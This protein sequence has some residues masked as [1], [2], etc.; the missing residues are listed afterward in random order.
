YV[1]IRRGIPD[2][3]V[4]REKVF[5]G[6]HSLGG[7]LTAAFADW[8]FDGDPQT[9][10]DAGYKQ[11]AGFFGL[12]TSLDFDSDGSGG[13]GIADALAAASGASPYV[14][15]PPFTP[16]TIQILGPFG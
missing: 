14:N 13:I 1:V 9:K 8:D 4:R 7:P 2:R 16:E 15:A 12:D 6:G 3:D 5:C 11:C 10:A